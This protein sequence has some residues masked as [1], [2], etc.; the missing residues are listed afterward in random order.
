M[1]SRQ[2]Y[3]VQI[4]KPAR[5]RAQV[6]N[7]AKVDEVINRPYYLYVQR[8][9]AKKLEAT[10]RNSVEYRYTDGGVTGQADAVTFELIKKA[11]LVYFG[12]EKGDLKCKITECKDKDG[13]CVQ[14]QSRFYIP[15]NLTHIH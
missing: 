11:L 15:T 14:K 9:L 13:N 10:K 1:A 6:R 5:G 8:S 7:K 3:I 2:K 12:N 4:E